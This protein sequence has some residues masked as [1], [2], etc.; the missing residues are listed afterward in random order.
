M[1]VAGSSETLV[2]YCKTV[3]YRNQE[4]LDLK[5]GLLGLEK[6]GNGETFK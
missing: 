4:V 3:R 5:L 1:E 2:S 6:G